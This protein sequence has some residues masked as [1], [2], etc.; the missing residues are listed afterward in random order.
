VSDLTRKA[1]VLVLGAV[2]LPVLGITLSV[3]RSEIHFARSQNWSLP[4][5]G[6]D[7]RDLLRGHYI[8]YRLEL[9]APEASY[10]EDDDPGCCLCLSR[11]EPVALSRQL[12]SSAQSCDGMLRSEYLSQLQRYYVPEARAQEAEQK[13]R[14]APGQGKARLVV[15]LDPAG[16]PQVR[17][18]LVDGQP[19]VP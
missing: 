19:L 16:E 12:C 18:L 4:V 3:A 9:P 15:A 5:A 14:A 8:Q 2:A 10:C 1:R 7:P 11:S 6:Y 13:L 17:Q